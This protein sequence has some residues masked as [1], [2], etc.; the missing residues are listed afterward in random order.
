MFSLNK[1][2]I[3]RLEKHQGPI[4]AR[5]AGARAAKGAILIFFHSHIEVN[6]NWLPP[7]IEPIALNS[8]T[9]VCPLVDIIKSENFAYISGDEGW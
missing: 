8:K 7:L 9:S 5:L 1:T 6:T 4:R 2:R 3:I